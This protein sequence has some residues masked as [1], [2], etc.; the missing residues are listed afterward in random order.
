MLN[1]KKR[2]IFRLE[3]KKLSK[4]NFDIL[5]EG[6][7]L[8]DVVKIINQSYENI[9]FGANILSYNT[10]SGKT[11]LFFDLDNKLHKIVQEEKI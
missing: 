3:N 4:E 6:M 9:G 5:Q 7:S 11:I 1:K 2:N 10:L 8:D